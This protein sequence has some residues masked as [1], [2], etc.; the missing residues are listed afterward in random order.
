LAASSS[1]FGSL[2]DESTNSSSTLSKKL[3]GRSESYFDSKFDDYIG[4]PDLETP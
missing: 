1:E 2:L 3:T 4:I